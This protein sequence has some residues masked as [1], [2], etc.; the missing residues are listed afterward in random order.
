MFMRRL[1]FGLFFS[2]VLCAQQAGGPKFDVISI[3]PVPPNAPPFMITP[4]FT[5]VLP[6]GQYV[7]PR[8]SVWGMIA[9]A[10]DVHSAWR[11]L[12]GLPKWATSA[13]QSYSVSA[14]PPEGFPQLSP[15]ENEGQVRL[16]MR[17]MLADRFHLR[18][19]TE[20]R[21]DEVFRLEIAKGGLKLK[22]VAAPVPPDKEGVVNATWGDDRIRMIARK[23]TMG[24]KAGLA[25]SLTLMLKTPVIDA[26]GLK[27]YFDFDVNWTSL[28][29]HSS[30]G[31]GSEGIAL[32]LSSLESQFGLRLTKGR[33]PMEYWVVDHVDPPNEN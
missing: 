30:S 14:K 7:D 5:T 10:Y 8:A 21:Q 6:G 26:T 23:T 4:D 25:S 18:I 33:E 24:G 31:F 27:N 32:L 29:V 17:A 20:T 3:H 28:D 13:G 12:E 19:H 22:E 11:Q 2:A 9:F 1:A 15:R 16:M